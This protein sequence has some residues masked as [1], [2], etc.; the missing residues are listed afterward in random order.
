VSVVPVEIA[1]VRIDLRLCG[2]AP[3][4]LERYAP[5]MRWT[6]AADFTLGLSP[7]RLESRGRYTRRVA[8]REGRWRVEGVEH[9]GWLDPA[10]GVGE[11][12]ADP[13]LAV[14]DGLV[15]A[16]VARHVLS[17]GGVLLHA[18][19]VRVDGRAHLFPARSGSG[20]STL[21]RLA[22]DVL[23]DEVVA[24]LPAPGGFTAQATPWWRS[25]GGAAPLAAVYA[26]AWEGEA[27]TPL[28]R[29]A[30]LRQLVTNLVL[31]LDGPE[32]RAC[33]LFA[34]A[35]IAAAVPFA[36][37]AFRTGTDVDALLRGPALARTG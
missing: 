22:G 11:A 25:V 8:V 26:L 31:P 16:A 13:S 37:L 24:V 9:S 14:V 23:A 5:F 34:A 7:G 19:A 10:S 17:C 2:P 28:P 29:P 3:G 32:E 20:K 18:A 4:A 33:A 15:R 35:R 6:G 21:A 27:V 1:G 12:V 30:A 36:R